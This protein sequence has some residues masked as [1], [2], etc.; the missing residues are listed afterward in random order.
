MRIAF[1]GSE[2]V[3][4]PNAFAKISEEIGWRLVERGHE[5]L[6]YGRRRYVPEATPYRGMMRVPVSSWNSKHL[7]TITFTFLSTLHL[8]RSGWADIAHYH[9]IGPS[10]LAVMPALRGMKSVVHIHSLDW[11]RAKWGLLA[12]RYLRLSEAAAVR[13]PQATVTVSRGLKAYLEDRYGRTVYYVPQ[14]LDRPVRRQPRVLG[15]LGLL[16]G[17]YLLYMGRLVP[18]KG[19]H[20][21][22]E[23]YRRLVDGSAGPEPPPLV[24]AGGG[25]HSDDYARRVQ[26]TAP[27]GVRFLGQVEG[28]LKE[29]LLSH[30]Y[31]YIQPS[32]LEGLSLALLEAMSYGNAVLVSDIP[33]NMEAVG[34]H[35][36]SFHSRDV[37]DLTERLAALLRDPTGVRALGPRAREHVLSSYS[38]DRVAEE[39]EAVYRQVLTRTGE[40]VAVGPEGRPA[41]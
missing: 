9:G 12:R 31:L 10:V 21:L 39:M 38:W 19:L 13:L 29:E 7:D 41:Q 18:E 37:D 11:Q 5:V 27:P 20:Y 30:A 34:E 17:R 36:V 32:E 1:L 4:Y 8:L 23:A 2:G 6:V 28:R 16:P 24:V 15:T 40:V 35:G 26:D 33:E 3:P 22:L 14:G 25:A